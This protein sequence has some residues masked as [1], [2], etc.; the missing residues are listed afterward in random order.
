MYYSIIKPADIANGPGVRV[1]LF[2]SGCRNHCHHCFQPQTWDFQYGQPFTETTI[3]TILT[4]L[5]PHYIRGITLLGGE[6]MEPENQPAL[7]DLLTRIRS[8]YGATKDV[9]CYT[10]Y[11]LE[12]DLLQGGRHLSGITDQL[13]SLIDVLVDGR[14]VQELHDFRLRFRGSSNQRL[15]DLPQTLSAGSVVLWDDAH[16]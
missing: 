14:F 7:L 6:P 16:K 4:Q 15:I 13:L 8:V 5:S 1:V 2:V 3:D 10:G 12:T 11:T 9:W